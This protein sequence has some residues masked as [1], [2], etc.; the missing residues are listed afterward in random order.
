MRRLFVTSFPPLEINCLSFLFL[1]IVCSSCLLG[2][3][4]A[5][6]DEMVLLPSF[7]IYLKIIDYLK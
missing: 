4:S 6:N 3:L 7:I 5:G 1:M 2:F